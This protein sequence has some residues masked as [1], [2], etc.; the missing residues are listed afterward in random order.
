MEDSKLFEILIHWVAS[1]SS[2]LNV[3]QDIRGATSSLPAICTRPET[4]DKHLASLGYKHVVSMVS[5]SG[6]VLHVHGNSRDGRWVI[7]RVMSDGCGYVVDM[8]ANWWRPD[9]WATY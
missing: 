8:G 1:L 2:V 4:F 9:E 7:M 5:L 3:Y 6:W